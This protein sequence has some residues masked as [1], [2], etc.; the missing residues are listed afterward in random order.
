MV[1]LGS[2]KAGFWIGCLAA[3]T[4]ILGAAYT[5]WM[6]KRVIFGPIANPKVAELK[7][8]H[9]FEVLAYGLLGAAVLI[10]GIYPEPLLKIMHASVEHILAL[11]QISKI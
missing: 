1:I 8:I 9:G 5:L 6:Y 11:S 2:L 3:T 10:F 4:L 7:D